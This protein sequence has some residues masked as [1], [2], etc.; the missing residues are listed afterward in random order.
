[1]IEVIETVYQLEGDEQVWLQRVTEAL[2]PSMSGGLGLH[3]YTYDL[4]TASVRFRTSVERRPAFATASVMGLLANTE[5]PMSGDVTYGELWKRCCFGSCT[6]VAPFESHPAAR[7]MGMRDMLALNAIDESGIGVFVGAPLSDRRTVSTGEA[8]AWMRVTSHMTTALRLRRR[9]R[10]TPVAVLSPTGR[11]EHAE[12]GARLAPDREALRDAVLRIERARGSLRDDP[13][14]ATKL[15]RPLTKER[16]TLID[17]FEADGRRYVVAFD[18]RPAATL[19][20]LTHREREVLAAIAEGKS[21][22]QV[23]FS[24]GLSDSTVRV[25]LARATKRLGLRTREDLVAFYR[26][27]ATLH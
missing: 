1:M 6:Q 10:A 27:E 12:H 4:A 15:W 17:R 9:L 23:A 20:V 11:L 22:K 16:Y 21:S 7:A 24:L 14:A 26:A 18:D 3:A 19:D 13:E 2:E 25:L 5:V 8:R